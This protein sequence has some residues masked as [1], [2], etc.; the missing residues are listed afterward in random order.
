MQKYFGVSLGVIILA[1]FLFFQFANDRTYPKEQ[2]EEKKLLV[3]LPISFQSLRPLK[4]NQHNDFYPDLRRPKLLIFTNVDCSQCEHLMRLL[5]KH[6]ESTGYEDLIV[7]IPSFQ[8]DIALAKYHDSSF[9]IYTMDIDEVTVKISR[10]P[11]FL[12]LDD[13]NIIRNVVQG[14]VMTREDLDF[15]INDFTEK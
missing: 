8:E 14:S 15:I 9:P 6:Q 11:T 3:G 5:R 13:C 4:E 7:A 10:V 2:T 1:V 12:F